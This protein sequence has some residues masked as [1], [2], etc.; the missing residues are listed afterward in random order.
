MV[1]TIATH[2]NHKTFQLSHTSNIDTFLVIKFPN[3]LELSWAK[4][5]RA[6]VKPGVG[7]RIDQKPFIGTIQVGKQLCFWLLC[8]PMPNSN[9][10]GWVAGWVVVTIENIAISAS[11]L[12][13]G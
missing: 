1:L 9:L 10:S 5:S 3:K 11:S 4:L 12:G 7:L 2:R 13:L 6:G 8:C